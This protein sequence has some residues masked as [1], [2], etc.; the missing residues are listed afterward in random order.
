[1]TLA[2]VQHMMEID[3]EECKR[4]LAKWAKGR[5]FD[6]AHDDPNDWPG[7][8][9]KIQRCVRIASTTSVADTT[10]SINQPVRN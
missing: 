4:H 2:Q 9:W 8:D 5:N 3:E 6:V 10:D 7:F 1:M